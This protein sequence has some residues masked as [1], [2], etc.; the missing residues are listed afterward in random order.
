[1]TRLLGDAREDLSHGLGDCCAQISHLAG[2][3]VD[4][5]TR[6]EKPGDF[7]F[8]L[9][10]EH[11]RMQCGPSGGTPCLEFY[12]AAILNDAVD[13]QR[14][15]KLGISLCHATTCGK[16]R[17]H[18]LSHHSGKAASMLLES[19]E[20]PDL[21]SLPSQLIDPVLISTPARARA[22]CSS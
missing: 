22:D 14:V 15:A 9:R 19:G 8:A 10:F 20:E 12:L 11:L 5:A 17:H 4:P 6:L 2:L 18:S 7:N 21:N 3:G 13:H 1:M 16:A